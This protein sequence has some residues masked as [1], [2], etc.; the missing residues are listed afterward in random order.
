MPNVLQHMESFRAALQIV[1]PL[2]DH[3]W[4]VLK[5]RLYMQRDAAEQIEY[6]RGE[7]LRALQATIPDPSYR[8]AYSKSANEAAERQWEQQQTPVRKRLARLA[9]DFIR[10]KWNNGRGLTRHTAPVFAVEVLLYTRNT[11]VEKNTPKDQT[12]SEGPRHPSDPAFVSLENMRWL[13]DSKVKPITEKFCRELFMCAECDGVAKGYAFEGMI[14]HFG[15]KHT[16]D[17]SQ[18]NIVVHWQTADWPDEPP[19]VPTVGDADPTLPVATAN[20]TTSLA[21]PGVPSGQLSMLYAALQT[22]QQPPVLSQN[23]GLGQVMAHA[24]NPNQQLGAYAPVPTAPPTA[25]PSAP[26]VP[27]FGASINTHQ[28]QITEVATTAIE[29]W[30]SLVGVKEMVESIRV[31]TVLHHVI[32]RFKRRF[33]HEPSLDLIT[34]ALAN[35]VLMRPVKSAQPLA[36]KTCVSSSLGSV[37][38][39][40]PYPHRLADNKNYNISSLI[41]HFKTVHLV[42]GD[43]DWREDMIEM[44]DEY[45]IKQLVSTVGM[46]DEKLAMV[47]AAFPK[48]FPHPLPRIGQIEASSGKTREWDSS[49]RSGITRKD[50][51]KLKR[52]NGKRG[53]QDQDDAEQSDLPEA[54]ED[55]YDPR[56]PAF[57]DSAPRSR[58]SLGEQTSNG[59]TVAQTMLDPSVFTPET[60]AALSKLAPTLNLGTALPAPSSSR[61]ANEA[62]FHANQRAFQRPADDMVRTNTQP[63][64]QEK[65]PSSRNK[66]D[67]ESN[68]TRN[69]RLEERET[70]EDYTQ[71]IRT[72]PATGGDYSATSLSQHPGVVPT[73]SPRHYAAAAAREHTQI[74]TSAAP[75][76]DRVPMDQYGRPLGHEPQRHDER[77][78]Q[79]VDEYGRR[80]P[81]GPPPPREDVRYVDQYGREVEVV[82][83]VDNRAP[84][85]GPPM[86]EYPPYG[87]TQPPHGHGFAPRDYG[88]PMAPAYSAPPPVHQYGPHT[89]HPEYARHAEPSYM[90]GPDEL[91][92]GQRMQYVD[93]FGRPIPYAPPY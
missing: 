40:K 25:P 26:A 20:A 6:Q 3:A 76:F 15:A 69:R 66:K 31:E 9:D 86:Y 27:Q 63:Q 37:S 47:A 44:A 68:R 61:A 50:K 54:G 83:M 38:M 64:Q 48:E 1:T 62:S 33:G 73:V 59:H 21:V 67:R 77:P 60:L 52:K 22:G 78:V 18:G 13:F 82:R 84:P 81:Y 17:F 30:N 88:P 79:Y 91:G 11:Y 12:N 29:I 35:H 56:R 87:Y 89:P 51:K 49:P 92:R 5:P 28:D 16:T 41:T 58:R 42:G 93:E 57:I 90:R 43:V 36:C 34:D 46:D 14:Q 65:G 85:Y 8:D 70:E 24:P 53:V 32:E 75:G 4:D 19:F 74:P 23:N 71:V 72:V 55:E 39:Y 2:D 45:Q 10:E 80:I 7:Q